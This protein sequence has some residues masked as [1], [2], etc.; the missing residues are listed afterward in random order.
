MHAS[1][2]CGDRRKHAIHWIVRW[3]VD[4]V[5]ELWKSGVVAEEQAFIDNGSVVEV[6]K[7][8]T[9]GQ[10]GWYVPD[11]VVKDHPS[12]ATWEGLKDPAIVKLF[13]TSATGDKGRFLGTDPSYSAYDGPLITTLGLNFELQ[14]SGSE[15][16]TVAEVDSAVAAKKPIL[17]Y[18]WSPT[19]AADV[20]AAWIKANESIWKAWFA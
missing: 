1:R 14:N 20:A 4:F 7:L 5:T 11:Y 15:A 10:I 3:T 18:W 9:T 2:N 8:G 19:A 17:L 12:L 6:G 13:A 16:A